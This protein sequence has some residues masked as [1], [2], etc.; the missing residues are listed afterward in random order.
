MFSEN[1][2]HAGDSDI[3]HSRT[4]TSDGLESDPGRATQCG[5]SCGLVALV[6][7]TGAAHSGDLSGG[8]GSLLLSMGTEGVG[9]NI[10]SA[11][12]YASR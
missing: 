4:K 8:G 5:R 3:E 7:A 9:P 6:T 11:W 12:R 1:V 10:V 2:I